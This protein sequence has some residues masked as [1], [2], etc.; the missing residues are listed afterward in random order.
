M[1]LIV[2]ILGPG[3]LAPKKTSFSAVLA[4]SSL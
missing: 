4:I 2:S 3:A 1:A